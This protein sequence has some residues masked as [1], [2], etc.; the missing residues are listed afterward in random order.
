MAVAETPLYEPKSISII[1]AKLRETGSTLYVADSA[2]TTKM[3][4]AVAEYLPNIR[5]SYCAVYDIPKVSDIVLI[6]SSQLNLSIQDGILRYVDEYKFNRQKYFDS[7]GNLTR[8]CR[9]I[10]PYRE[11]TF[12]NS[13]L[14]TLKVV[15][16]AYGC[17]IIE[18]QSLVDD[19]NITIEKTSIVDRRMLSAFLPDYIEEFKK[20]YNDQTLFD[21]MLEYK[22]IILGDYNKMIIH[23]EMCY[24][25]PWNVNAML[26]IDPDSNNKYWIRP[27]E[28]SIN[29]IETTG[30]KKVRSFL[31][32][33]VGKLLAEAVY[34]DLYIYEKRNG[35]NTIDIS[36]DQYRPTPFKTITYN[37][38]G[39][40]SINKLGYYTINTNKTNIITVTMYKDSEIDAIDI[41]LA[42]AAELPVK[43]KYV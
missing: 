22:K 37:L 35:Y 12:S 2:F 7:E 41:N 32:S 34:H 18:R 15:F 1:R 14:K 19:L 8:I 28:Q 25:S 10:D 29:I 38:A 27:V 30:D 42:Y 16:D 31:F 20:K 3:L 40:K 17:F 9:G 43:F 26:V 33:Q 36:V 4:D 5:G 21:D 39:D 13:K 6:Q 11:Y 23:S 24:S